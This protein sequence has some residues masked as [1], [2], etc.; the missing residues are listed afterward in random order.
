MQTGVGGVLYPPHSLDE[1]ML[2]PSL[3][4]ALAPTVDDVW[5]WAAAVSKGT[6]VVPLPNGRRTAKGVGKPREFSLMS[7]NLNPKDD[8]NRKAFDKIME[9]FSGIRRRL[10]DSK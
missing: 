2:D 7:V 10:M 1:K 4:M 6:Y 9:E 3:F 5:F 8:K